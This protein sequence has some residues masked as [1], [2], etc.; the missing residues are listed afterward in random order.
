M[1]EIVPTFSEEDLIAE[2][3]TPNIPSVWMKDFKI[4]QLDREM[5]I[6]NIMQ[7][8]LIMEETVK[9]EKKNTH[10]QGQENNK[11]L[12]N[13]CRVHNGG[14]EWDDCR[15]TP[16][17]KNIKTRTVITIPTIGIIGEKASGLVTDLVMRKTQKCRG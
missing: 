4:L 9:V 16:Q 15:E 1:R 12:K 11:H 13:P 8:L 5:K 6:K 3:I 10:R 7:K 14:H 2:V 17:N